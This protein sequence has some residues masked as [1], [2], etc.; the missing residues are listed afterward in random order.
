[1]STQADNK[2]TWWVFH[3]D[4]LAAA[5]EEFARETAGANDLTKRAEIHATIVDFLHS[6]AC[7]K[8]GMSQGG[9]SS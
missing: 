1:M 6:N 5:A 9:K 8:R 3:R 7:R 2:P 4:D